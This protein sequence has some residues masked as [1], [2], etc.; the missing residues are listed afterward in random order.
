MSVYNMPRIRTLTA[1]ALIG[2]FVISVVS[3]G[4][5][6]ET[7]LTW[8]MTVTPWVTPTP[9]VQG[10]L[11]FFGNGTV[12]KNIPLDAVT[13]PYTYSGTP[14]ETWGGFHIE[15]PFDKSIK[16]WGSFNIPDNPTSPINSNENQPNTEPISES[17]IY[18]QWDIRYSNPE[19]TWF[20][21][22]FNPKTGSIG[23]VPPPVPTIS[24]CGNCGGSL[25]FYSN[26]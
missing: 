2:L 10:Q 11:T 3:A 9:Y 22:E 26:V 17:Q 5:A 6:V 1:S 19:I 7:P 20:N 8:K 23:L 15:P 21:P 4:N 18:Q 14:A 12:P 16:W 25:G 24:A 13:S